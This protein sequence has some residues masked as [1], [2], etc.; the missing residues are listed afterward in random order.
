[1]SKTFKKIK[2]FTLSEMLV[3]LLLTLI[4]VGLAFSVLGLVQGQMNDIQIG[5]EERAQDNL[6]QQALWIDFNSYSDIY[7]SPQ[8][9]TLSLTDEIEKKEYRFFKTYVL[10]EKDTIFT[11]FKINRAFF[12]G[13]E[14]NSG[15]VDALEFINEGEQ[16]KTLFVYKRNT[17]TDFMN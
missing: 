7:F 15:K 16:L 4:V 13:K 3:V 8:D 5:Y 1:M 17:A 9:G 6:L 2:A 10:N 12:L 14:V 11:D